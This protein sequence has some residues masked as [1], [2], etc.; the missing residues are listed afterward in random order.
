MSIKGDKISYLSDNNKESMELF[1]ENLILK[2]KTPSINSSNSI[3]NQ[4][5]Y[6]IDSE[7]SDN[8][9]QYFI[10]LLNHLNPPVTSRRSPERE[11]KRVTYRGNKASE[12]ILNI[13]KN[14]DYETGQIK[15]QRKRKKEGLFS[16]LIYHRM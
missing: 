1:Q 16:M 8:T 12:E 10:G 2:E 3:L 6:T 5:D 7:E 14:E 13:Y 9:K 15:I 11:M 4:L